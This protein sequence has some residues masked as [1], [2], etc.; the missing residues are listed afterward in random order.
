M[1]YVIGIDVHRKFIQV[2]LMDA[3][4]QEQFNGS[5]DLR[6]PAGIVALFSSVP[7]ETPIAMEG[8]FGWMWLADLLVGMGFSVHLAD[9]K[10]VKMI[11][12]VRLS[13]DTVDARTLAHL[14][15]TNFLPEAYLAPASLQRQRMLLRHREGLLKTRTMVKNRVHALLVRYNVHPSVSD[16]FGRSGLAWLTALEVPSP[17]RAMLGDHLAHLAFLNDQVQ[18]VRHRLDA[19][20]GPDPRVAWLVSVP[21]VGKLTAYFLLAEIGR[22]D[23]FSRPA[24]LSSYCG[25]CPSTD[26]SA[27]RTYHGRT[28]GSGRRLLKWALVEAAHTAVRRDSYFASVF[29]HHANRKGTGKAYVAV[30]RK[31]AVVVWHLLSEERPYRVRGKQPQVGSAVAMTDRA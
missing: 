8:S 23:R 2:C 1:K 10:R 26:Q 17:G 21:G 29:H 16:I 28:R 20:L 3:D 14:L 24:K 18:R 19:V 4:G 25:L 7:P 30:A 5:W 13:S 22:I 15:R 9:S 31:M 6:D 27:G 11:A 12:E